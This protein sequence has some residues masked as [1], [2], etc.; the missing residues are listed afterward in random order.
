GC[1]LIHLRPAPHQFRKLPDREGSRPRQQSERDR[2]QLEYRDTVDVEWA[3]A[4]APGAKIVL[5]TGAERG[6]LAEAINLAVVR[7]LGNTISN[8]WST[9]E[10]LGNPAQFNRIERILQQ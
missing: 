3:H 2:A 6:S 8:S 10:G 7:H 1:F 9:I 4:M 5:V